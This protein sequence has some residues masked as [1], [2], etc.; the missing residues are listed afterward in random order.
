MQAQSGSGA[1]AGSPQSSLVRGREGQVEHERGIVY[2]AVGATYV[3]DAERSAH[4]ARRQHPDLPICLFSDVP[5]E[6]PV[7]DYKRTIKNPHRRSKLECILETPF[8]HT[9]FLDTDTR[10]ISTITEPFGLLGRYDIAACHVENRHPVSSAT[11]R[12]QAEGLD[13]GFTGFNSGVVYYRLN[14]AVRLFFERWASEYK[15][16]NARWDQPIMRK[17]LWEMPEVKVIVIPP[18]YNIR[19]LRGLLFRSVYES[20]ARLL[21]LPWYKSDGSLPW[22]L[23]RTIRTL[24]VYPG[25]AVTMIRAFFR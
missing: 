17:L 10:V 12:L 3:R 25:N 7:F 2:V 21:H 8:K 22:R 20:E 15:Q 14:D 23:W 13:P 9:L 18:E 5:S 24:R 4:S 1:A 16:E 19:T 6:D 11:A